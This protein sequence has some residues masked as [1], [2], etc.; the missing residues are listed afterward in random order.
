[1]NQEEAQRI[2]NERIKKRSK[3]KTKGL[4]YDEDEFLV[5]AKSIQDNT[6]VTI[7]NVTGDYTVTINDEF[8]SVTEIGSTVT[9]PPAPTLKGRTIEISNQSLG[10]IYITSSSQ[11][12]NND[13]D[14]TI[15]S[16]NTIT[17]ISDGTKYIVK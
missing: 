8:I 5:L 17:V 16:G 3:T 7:S 1:M 12:G 10:D 4:V 11:I 2:L 6:E 15:L 13:L 9:L 14:W